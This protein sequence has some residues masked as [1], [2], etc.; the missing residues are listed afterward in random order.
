MT[1]NSKKERVASLASGIVL[2]VLA[3]LFSIGILLGIFDFGSHP[4]GQGN[5]L[6][7]LGNMLLSVYGFSSVLIPVFFIVAGAFCFDSRWSVQRALCLLISVIPFFTVV[8][9]EKMGRS[10]MA[11]DTTAIAFVKLTLLVVV[12]TLLVVTE[13][14]LAVIAAGALKKKINF[15]AFHRKDNASAEESKSSSASSASSGSDDSANA[16]D[17]DDAAVDA[18]SDRFEDTE[19][20]EQPD[21]EFQEPVVADG[22]FG[23]EG[24]ST[25]RPG[26]VAAAID[27]AEAEEKANSFM[28]RL[29]AVFKGFFKKQ[30]DRLNDMAEFSRKQDEG[31]RAVRESESAGENAEPEIVDI[32]DYF[33]KPASHTVLS[34]G[35]FEDAGEVTVMDS[36]DFVVEDVESE[37][38]EDVSRKQNVESEEPVPQA[39]SA[40]PSEVE[41]EENPREEIPVD[42]NE[43]E[44]ATVDESVSV[45]AAGFDE[46]AGPVDEEDIIAQFEHGNLEWEAGSFANPFTTYTHDEENGSAVSADANDFVDF[47]RPSADEKIDDGINDDYDEEPVSADVSPEP[48]VEPASYKKARDFVRAEKP[49]AHVVTPEPSVDSSDVRAE[50]NAVFE[51]MDRDAREQVEAGEPAVEVEP[52][53]PRGPESNSTLVDIAIVSNESPDAEQAPL[54]AQSPVVEQAPLQAQSPVVEQAPL[55]VQSPA[56]EKTCVAQES[57]VVENDYASA[58]GDF[59]IDDEEES[60]EDLDDIME[61]NPGDIVEAE[62]DEP[63]IENEPSEIGTYAPPKKKPGMSSEP[64]NIPYDLLTA[65]EDNPYWIIDDETKQAAQ[66]LKDTLAEFKIEAEVTGI[67]KGP[68]VTMFEMLPAPGVKLNRIVAL[69]DNIALRLAASSVRIVAPIPGK[70][71]VG[72]EVPN[73]SRAI[74]S[75]RECLEQDRPE[76]K[77]MGVPVVL[78]KDIQGSTQIIDLVKTPHLL[79][80]G[81]TGAGKS[82]CVNSMIVSMLYKRSPHE[83]KMILIDPKIVELKLYND[84]PHLLTPVITEPKKAMQ[85]LQYC[86]CEMERRYAL[87]DG[88]SVRDISS[89]NRKI[90]EKHIATEHLPYLIVIIDEFA[91]LMAT[92]GKQLEGVLARLAAMSRAVGIHLVLATQ[93]PSIDVITG[94]IKANIPSRIAF[95]VAS[96]IDSRIILDQL[97]AEKLLGKGDMLYTSATDP[98]PCRIQGTFV[99]DSEVESVVNAVK[100]W[101]EPD[102]IDDEIFVDDDEDDGDENMSLFNPDGADPLYDKALDI[103]VQAGKASASYIQRRLKIGYNRAAR[104]VEEMEE[105]G[106]VGP[107]NGSKPRELIH[108]P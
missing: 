91:D 68:V 46:S 61:E 94:L 104:L 13:Y 6:F 19:I 86:L 80:A 22:F 87:L 40:S 34:E 21:D 76:W 72:I 1:Y 107:A 30:V 106:I 24:K 48:Y 7:R 85:A 101:G 78:G 75:I 49:V 37:S 52:P 71:A 65:Y 56:A 44:I 70:H 38:S 31:K 10:V 82:V 79:I 90:V 96:K 63:E 17:F 29:S 23:D 81:A 25:A 108:I 9:A 62:D 55:H 54:Q 2:F 103:V 89:Y 58:M 4:A 97:G 33:Q 16:G 64:Y 100:A 53:M 36:P 41:V 102:Y 11:N 60:D 95:M 15:A 105:R 51:K 14:L 92:T 99:S 73:K 88:M 93:R 84:I 83:V 59:P 27:A 12:T 77:K 57:P 18:D 26:T 5:L 32:N 42:F 74:I 66:N 69:Q 39:D 3:T 67:Q 35:E 50:L 47:V 98:F 8:L 28:G 45:D 20:D 43:D